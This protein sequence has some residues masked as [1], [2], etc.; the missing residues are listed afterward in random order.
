MIILSNTT[1]S[2]QV[3]LASAITTN[4]LRCYVA[5]RDTTATTITPNRT[6]TNTNST[7]PVTLLSAPASLSQKIV[8]YLSIYNSDTANAVVTVYIN[9]SSTTYKL[10]EIILGPGEKLEFQEGHG[11][12]SLTSDG[13]LKVGD[14]QG[15]NAISKAINTVSISSNV[16]TSVIAYSN[17]TGL[18]FPVTA[19][20]TYW[21]KFSL[22]FT[23]ST[24]T[25]GIVPSING[26]T[27]TYL[28]YIRTIHVGAGI[29]FYP[30][31]DYDAALGAPNVPTGTLTS[32]A[33]MEGIITVSASGNV[34]GRVATSIAG[35]SVTVRA[36]S[37]IYYQRLN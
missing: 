33:T 15:V 19:G 5:Y 21:F 14:N 12:R 2:L 13:S 35:S 7:T 6:V 23:M 28:A 24:T 31:K 10:T 17:I 37:L 30:S 18:Q 26:P 8:D 11:F 22:F 27:K 36:G 4:Q 29:A 25:R 32:A 3:V 16:V 20:E 9:S 1:D 34:I